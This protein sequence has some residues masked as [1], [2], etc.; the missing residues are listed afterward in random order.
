[1]DCLLAVDVEFDCD[2]LLD[3]QAQTNLLMNSQP[4]IDHDYSCRTT[5]ILGKMVTRKYL[6]QNLLLGGEL[7]P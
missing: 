4:R 5:N 1:M 3:L 7:F 6:V 2:C